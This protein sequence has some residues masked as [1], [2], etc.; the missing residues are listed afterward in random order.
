MLL[1]VIFVGI[2]ILVLQ[3]AAIFIQARAITR[4]KNQLESH[5]VRILRLNHRVVGEQQPVKGT[6]KLPDSFL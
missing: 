2:V 5:D 4:C 6:V 1:T 3:S